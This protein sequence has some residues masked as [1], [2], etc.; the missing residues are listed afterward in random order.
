MFLFGTDTEGDIESDTV[1]FFYGRFWPVF[2][3][4][5]F[6]FFLEV[7]FLAGHGVGGVNAG[8]GA[9]DRPRNF[10]GVNR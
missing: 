9:D 4:S 1:V 3:E 6:F 2:L 10:L 7:S 5:D 8:G